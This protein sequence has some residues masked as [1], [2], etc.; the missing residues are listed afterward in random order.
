MK[1]QTAC[2]WC[3]KP[4]IYYPSTVNQRHH[5]CSRK[6]LQAFR[7]KKTNP[8]HYQE[9]GNYSKNA[10]RF[11]EM[12]RLLNPTRM[13]PETRKKL[14]ENRLGTGEGKTY[15]KTYGR[16][17]HRVVAEQMLG[18][19][20]AKDEIVHHIDGN[21]RNN[22]PENLQVMTRSEHSRLHMMQRQMKEVTKHAV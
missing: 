13:T 18:R 7:S 22:A 9:Y 8:D 19:P 4:V 21:K 12:N 14:R 3:G 17:T 1:Y 6:C 15:T 10:E 5:F 2:D 16:H 20:L 11:S